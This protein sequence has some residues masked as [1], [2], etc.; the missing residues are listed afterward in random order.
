MSSL[1]RK[2]KP[3][4]KVAKPAQ[5]Y[6]PGQIPEGLTQESS[7]EEEEGE[8]EQQKEEDDQELTAIDTE[9]VDQKPTKIGISSN[10]KNIDIGT[11]VDVQPDIKPEVK[12]ESSSSEE[13]ESSEEESSEEEVSAPRLKP[14]FVPKRARETVLQKEKESLDS[15]EAHKKREKAE[16]ERKQASIDMVADSIRRELAEK[17]ATDLIPDVDDTDGLEPDAE[18][19]AWRL[20][21]LKR[22][23]RHKEAQIKRDEEI[24][25]IERRRA[26]PEELRLKEDMELAKQKREDKYKDRQGGTY[27]QKFWHKGAFHQDFDVLKRDLSGPTMNQVDLGKLPEVMQVRDFGKTKQTKYK[28]LKDE[29]T[30]LQDKP[31][32][33]RDDED[34]DNRYRQQDDIDRDAFIAEKEKERSKRQR[35][36]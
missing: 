36:I 2:T 1:A 11:A 24:A 34:V 20:R 18:F 32:K 28:T 9:E 19:D 16:E 14:T 33:K 31:K 21:E 22:I 7:D 4:Q 29:D 12:E 8:E 26:M 5:R 13:E 15:E 3:S 30:T 10:I 17:D 6:R 23:Q 25:E 27:M 35:V